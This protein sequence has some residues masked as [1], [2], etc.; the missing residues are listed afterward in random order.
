MHLVREGSQL[1][2]VLQE[3]VQDQTQVLQEEQQL[4]L[5]QV[6]HE[7]QRTIRSSS[8]VQQDVLLQHLK[9]L[10]VKLHTVVVAQHLVQ[11]LLHLVQLEE[12][13]NCSA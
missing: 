1:L 10:D 5:V 11:E 7:A 13:F 4:T 12:V 8:E 3:H 9:Q 2:F 6:V